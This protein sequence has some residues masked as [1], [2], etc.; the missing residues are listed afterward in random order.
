MNP[1]RAQIAALGTLQPLPTGGIPVTPR[2]R[3]SIGHRLPAVVLDGLRDREAIGIQRYGSPLC[4]LNGRDALR[5]LLEELLDGVHYAA[6][7]AI[8][9]EE[10]A[11]DAGALWDLAVRLGVEADGVIRMRESF[12]LPT[13]QTITVSVDS[14]CQSVTLETLG[15]EG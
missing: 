6:Q 4:A 7:G 2:L 1:D 8:E 10:H 14:V 13:V 5:D 3:A 12:R 15:G 11:E 9:A